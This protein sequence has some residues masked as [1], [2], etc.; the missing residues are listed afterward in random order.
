MLLQQ[1]MD[2]CLGLQ[3]RLSVSVPLRLFSSRGLG[4][5]LRLR[6]GLRLGLAH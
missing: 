1:F 6:L 5:R 4:L 2:I 3:Q